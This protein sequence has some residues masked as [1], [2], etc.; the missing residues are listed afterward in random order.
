GYSIG[1]RLVK[2]SNSLEIYVDPQLWSDPDILA[3]ADKVETYLDAKPDL[4]RY[5]RVEIKLKS[6]KVLAGEMAY[7]RGSHQHPFDDEIMA[8]KFRTLAEV[9]LP[10]ERVEAI[11]Q[12]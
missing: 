1:A 3:V 11:M 10:G 6:G 2:G 4:P 5:T 9:V 7:T 12:T 8:E